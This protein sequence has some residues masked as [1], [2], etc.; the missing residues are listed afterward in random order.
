MTTGASFPFYP[1]QPTPPFTLALDDSYFLVRL[2]DAQAFFSASRFTKPKYL[3]IS[4]SVE[5][6][7]HPGSPPVQSLH[8]V[9]SLTRNVPCR[10]GLSFNLTDWL[11]ARTTDWLRI[12]LDYT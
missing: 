12:K 11:P 5:N 1:E 10:L 4:S 7:F 3:L 9:S 8:Q 6:S 2:H